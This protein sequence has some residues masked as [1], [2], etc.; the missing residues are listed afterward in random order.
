MT[1]MAWSWTTRAS[2]P[3]Q[4]DP[5]AW[6]APGQITRTGPNGCPVGV[7][8]MYLVW[9]T[10]CPRR[11]ARPAAGKAPGSSPVAHH[12]YGRP[13]LF[14]V[15]RVSGQ[16]RRRRSYMDSLGRIQAFVVS[17]LNGTWHTA[18]EVPAAPPTTRA[19]TR[20]SIRCRAVP[21]ATAAPAGSTPTSLMIC[22]R[23]WS[24]KAGCFDC[25]W[26]SADRGSARQ[27]DT[28]STLLPGP[29]QRRL[30]RPGVPRLTVR[31]GG[32]IAVSSYPV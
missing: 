11:A 27:G 31:R 1:S 24:A 5:Q 8:S 9:S 13:G 14:Y 25:D 23:L 30:V 2:L 4:A 15:V 21:R 32:G 10:G 16:L 17:E 26:L 6:P 22:R 28:I 29:G 19:F 18:I 7:V 12:Q 20:R 3:E